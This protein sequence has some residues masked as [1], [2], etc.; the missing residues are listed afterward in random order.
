MLILKEIKSN[1]ALIVAVMQM[2]MIGGI[3]IHVRLLKVVFMGMSSCR[4]CFIP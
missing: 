3:Y 4:K 2:I 1:S